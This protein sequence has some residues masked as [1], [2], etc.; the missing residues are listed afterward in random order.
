MRRHAAELTK[1]HRTNAV[2]EKL[3]ALVAA[4]TIITTMLENMHV[5]TLNRHSL[6]LLPRAQATGRPRAAAERAVEG[7]RL[8]AAPRA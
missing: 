4:R 3:A 6:R 7:G 1:M 2:T 8:A 5:R